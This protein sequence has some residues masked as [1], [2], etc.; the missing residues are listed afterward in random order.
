MS[1]FE[2]KETPMRVHPGAFVILLAVLLLSGLAVAAGLDNEDKEW[3]EEVAPIILPAEQEAYK[4]VEDKADRAEFRRIFWARRDPDLATPENEFRAEFDAAR[5]HADREFKVPGSA[6]AQTDCGRT[7]ILLGEPDDTE[8]GVGPSSVLYR[9]PEVWIYRDKPSRTF[10]GGEA[11]IAFDD[12]CRAPR[13]IQQVLE[14][15]AIEKIVQ[16]QIQYLVG[17]DGRLI[18]LEDQ[19]PKDSPARVLLKSPREDFALALE[20]QFMRLSEEE[21]GVVGLVRGKVDGK[22]ADVVV[23]TS[24][25]GED[26]EEVRWTEQATR[27]DVQPDGAF[28]ASFGTSLPPGSYTFSVGVLVGEG[29]LGALVSD[30]I[31]VPDFSKVET[32]PDGTTKKVPSV[33]SILFAREIEQLPPGTAVDPEH[34]YAAF[35]LG[36]TQLVP[37][38][39]RDLSPS[40]QVTFFYLVY[41]LGV[42]PATEKGDAVIA[43]SILKDGRQAVAKAPESPVDTPLAAS[44]VGPVPM[45]AYPPGNYVAQLRVTDRVTNKTVVQNERFKILAPEG[46]AP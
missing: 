27:A 10:E 23:A 28:V 4:K 5:A 9:V 35:R 20:T 18:A 13:G 44:S 1:R 21:T 6:G 8:I 29:P 32:A 38:F 45:G 11:R 41:G 42:D 39:G 43:F 24:A 37:H 15:F 17:E 3:L 40:D 46:A 25:T 34:P 31:K 30:K 22:V 33:A 7:Y 26:G 16:T 14:D 2:N 19:L 36:E 12:S